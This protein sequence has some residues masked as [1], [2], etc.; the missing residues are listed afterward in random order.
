MSDFMNTFL[1]SKITVI[2]VH[3]VGTLLYQF[4]MHG[5]NSNIKKILKVYNETI[6]RAIA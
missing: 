1:T 5:E 2:Y 4:A 6:N 3:I